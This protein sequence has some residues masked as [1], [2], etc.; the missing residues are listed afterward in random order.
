[1]LNTP[2]VPLGHTKQS[3]FQFLFLPFCMSKKKKTRVWERDTQVSL[4]CVSPVTPAVFEPAPSSE[5]T[6]GVRHF[7]QGALPRRSLITIT[8]CNASGRVRGVAGYREEPLDTVACCVALPPPVA[9]SAFTL[10]H[11]LSSTTF[12][13]L[14]FSFAMSSPKAG[15]R[16]VTKAI[17]DR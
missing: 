2:R 4:H 5:R 11:K 7:P 6:H 17:S 12:A 14:D 3:I 1:M 8:E 13:Q 9:R 15:G 16:Q 10:E